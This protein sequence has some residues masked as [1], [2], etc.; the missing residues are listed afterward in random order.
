MIAAISSHR[1]LIGRFVFASLGAFA[2]WL[3][4]KYGTDLVKSFDLLV[5]DVLENF[6]TRML[7]SWLLFV[8]FGAIFSIIL[9]EP[10]TLRQAFTAGA[11]CTV[12]L[13]NVTP[14]TPRRRGGGG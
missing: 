8:G 10:K 12:L 14:T 11:T 4:L 2:L 7:A 9:I 5:E 3:R 6:Q 13:G 1:D